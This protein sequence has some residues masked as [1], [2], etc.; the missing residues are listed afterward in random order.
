MVVKAAPNQQVDLECRKATESAVRLCEESGHHV[1][2]VS[3]RPLAIVSAVSRPFSH[4]LRWLTQPVNVQVAKETSI[5][6]ATDQPDRND[7]MECLAMKCN[8]PLRILTCGVCL[9]ALA[10]DHSR[11]VGAEDSY[12]T[13]GPGLAYKSLGTYSVERLQKIVTE[14]RQAEGFAKFDQSYPAPKHAVKLYRVRYQSVVP[15]QDNRCTLA[16]GL[17]AIPDIAARELAVV[18]YQHGTTFGRTTAPSFPENSYETRLMIA[19][20]PGHGYL[21]VAPDYFGK[22]ESTEP[23]SYTVRDSTR[24][25]CF[26]ML[27][28]SRSVCESMGIKQGPLHL[29]GWSQGGWCTMTFLHKLES[30]Q[31]SVAAASTASAFNDVFPSVQRW[32][33]G[34]QPTDAEY[35]PGCYTLNLFSHEFYHGLTGLTDAAIRPEYQKLAGQLYRG[36]ISYATFSEGTPKTVGKYL[37][38]EFLAS[39]ARGEGRYWD[40]LRRSEA[41]RWQRKTPLHSVFGQ[42]DEACPPYIAKLSIDYQQIARGAEGQAIDAGPKADHRGTFLYA[43]AHQKT[44]FDTL[45]NRKQ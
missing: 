27:M 19:Q 9:A 2:E 43:V 42:I 35:I 39:A 10:G 41:Y 37:R 12:V 34:Y 21:L 5:I 33:L 8:L 3:D 7:S 11:G 14:E 13:L 44:W 25:A 20:F 29:T 28:A 36:E 4:S 1:E 22:G 15:E 31:V 32:I 26:D 16:T 45:L 18:S 40:I 23:D 30:V 24:Q 6:C 17:I 38:P